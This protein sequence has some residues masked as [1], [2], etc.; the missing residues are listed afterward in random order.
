M[1]TSPIQSCPVRCSITRPTYGPRGQRPKNRSRR[2]GIT[3]FIG[4]IGGGRPVPDVVRGRG[5]DDASGW[6][7]IHICVYCTYLEVRLR[8]IYVLNTHIRSE[9]CR[10]F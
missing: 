6:V 10:V 7:T 4:E 3:C 5:G 2:S 9:R 1:T 8:S